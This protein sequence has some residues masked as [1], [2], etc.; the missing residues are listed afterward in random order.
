MRIRTFDCVR[1]YGALVVLFAHLPVLAGSSVSR[2]FNFSVYQF[3]IGYILLD[4]FFVMSGFLITSIILQEK[5]KNTFSFKQ[6]YLNR[7]LRIFPIYYLT[8]ILVAVFIS[9]DYLIYPLFFIAN[10]FFAFHNEVHPLNNTWT[11]AVEEH[12]Y[13][14]WP[15]LLSAFSLKQCKII[16]GFIIPLTA[17]ITVI[18]VSYILDPDT[19]SSLVYLGTTTRCLSI[20][21]G[22]FL[23]FNKSWLINLSKQRFEKIILSCIGIYIL[24]YFMPV[25]PVLNKVPQYARLVCI[26]PVISTLLIIISFRVNFSGDT[27][28]KKIIFN[29][30]INYIGLM[31]YGLYLFHYPVFY[32]FHM[33]DWQTPVTDDTGTYWL[34]IASAFLLTIISYHF[35]EKPV[36]R[37]GRKISFSNKASEIRY[38]NTFLEGYRESNTFQ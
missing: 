31:S 5:E 27:L 26:V 22:A 1:G 14:L 16:T 13:L 21:L 15:V 2:L 33:I 37:F 18:I 6:F 28:L 12:F 30:V 24:F 9:T 34:A 11:L 23:A 10:Y 4:M 36:I 20:S 35:V 3:N 7:S 25:L 38:K 32:Y 19:A 29:D 17:L 8:I